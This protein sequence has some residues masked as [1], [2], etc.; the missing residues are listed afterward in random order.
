MFGV[1]RSRGFF[2][3]G[4]EYQF[5]GWLEARNQWLNLEVHHFRA[6]WTF[7]S[8]AIKQGGCWWRTFWFASLVISLGFLLAVWQVCSA[9]WRRP[10]VLLPR[11][12]C[13]L[14]DWDLIKLWITR[15]LPAIALVS[16]SKAGNNGLIYRWW[17]SRSW[18]EWCLR[19]WVSFLSPQ[20]KWN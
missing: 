17:W 18:L 20:W 4:E 11:A 8:G 7:I 14:L 9:L 10:R 6:A 13:Q 15:F 5:L 1:I 19:F 12:T 3:D 2:L 16:N